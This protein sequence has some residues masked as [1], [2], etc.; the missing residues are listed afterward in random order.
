MRGMQATAFC[1][2]P[3][4]LTE[5]LPGDLGRQRSLHRGVVWTG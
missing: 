1:I 5:A 3:G 2:H 4:L